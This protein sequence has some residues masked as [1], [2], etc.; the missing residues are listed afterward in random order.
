MIGTRRVGRPYKNDHK[1]EVSNLQVECLSKKRNDYN[2][3][4]VYMKTVDKEGKKKMRRI[5]VLADEETLM[6]Y[7]LTDKLDVILKVTEKI[8]L[9]IE[10]SQVGKVYSIDA[11]FES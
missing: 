7:W 1:V 9:T 8:I 10:P 2:A 5:T 4:I 11:E 3:E 6:P